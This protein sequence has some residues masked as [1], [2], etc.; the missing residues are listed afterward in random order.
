MNIEGNFSVPEGHLKG[1]AR[2]LH[3][4]LE[5]YAIITY[6]QNKILT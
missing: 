5:K 3:V 1:F 6:H 4:K 2:Y